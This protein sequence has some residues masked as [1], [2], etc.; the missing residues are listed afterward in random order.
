VTNSYFI[1]DS[2]KLTPQINSDK[3]APTVL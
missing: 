1:T 3:T 2:R